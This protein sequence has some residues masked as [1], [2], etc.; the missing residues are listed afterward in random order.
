M[1]RWKRPINEVLLGAVAV[2]G[3]FP[4]LRVR[5]WERGGRDF[6]SVWVS[7]LWVCIWEQCPRRLWAPSL[8]EPEAVGG[9]WDS[10]LRAHTYGGGGGPNGIIE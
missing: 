4:F 8:E 2:S 7:M 3:K 5:R 6:L 10:E 9:H 1:L